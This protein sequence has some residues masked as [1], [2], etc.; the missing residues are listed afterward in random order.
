MADYARPAIPRF[1]AERLRELYSLKLLDTQLE[2]RFQRY[3]ELVADLFDVPIAL[4]SL[5]DQDRQWFKAVCG[6]DRRELPRD[7]SF[8]GH[9]VAADALLVV[10]DAHLDPRFAGNPL[11][12][13]SP[14]IRFYAGAPIHGPSGLPL[15]TLCV[16]DSR[17]HLHEVRELERLER[18]AALVEHEIMQ[19]YQLDNLRQ[20]LERSAYYDPLTGL[21]NR[22]LL[23]DRLEYSVRVGVHREGAI[24]LALID[25][26]RFG[27]VNH[28]YGWEGG[29]ALLRA[30]A[31]ALARE[32]PEP[33]VVAR[34]QDDRFAVLDPLVDSVRSGADLAQSILA[35]F[36]KPFR[37]EG[38][39]VHLDARIGISAFPAHGPDANTLARH[40]MTAMRA[41]APGYRLYTPGLETSRARRQLLASRLRGAVDD[42]QVELAYQAKLDATGRALRGVEALAR[43]HD[44]EL[45]YVPP[46]ELF[47]VAEETGLIHRLGLQLLRKACRQAAQWAEDGLAIPLAVN[48]TATELRDSELVARV[49]GV[50][51]ETGVPGTRITLEVTESMLVDVEDA[52]EKMQALTQLGVCFA[53]DDFG[54][55]YSSFAYLAQLPV[56]SVKIDR[57]LVAPMLAH[58]SAGRTVAGIIQ[59]A[60]GLDMEVVA[61]GVES[62]EHLEFLRE[63]GCDEVQ[64]FFLCQPVAPG[65]LARYA[66]ELPVT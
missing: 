59:L 56:H 60:H 49:A 29:N 6:L 11:V 37:V 26:D 16:I 47:R 1:E 19:S 30:V 28:T 10:P 21:P 24:L 22:R 38:H 50:L 57:R 54:T 27:A 8:C 51:A 63:A 35:A 17:P 42:D 34:W 32:H 2:E 61:E 44:P 41:G 20:E 53:I 33:C 7:H 52:A 64:G 55:G 62:A 36:S 65:A 4:I 5:V 23:I 43:W 18:L 14:Y 31:A 12:T 46:E 9:A 3:T 25:I 13:G 45:G 40:A 66:R 39:R 58:P 48:L 15:G